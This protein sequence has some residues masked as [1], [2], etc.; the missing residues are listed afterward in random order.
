MARNFNTNQNR[1]LYVVKGY[2]TAEAFNA[3]DAELSEGDIA[4]NVA[5]KGNDKR[6]YLQYK[7]ADT[8]LRSPLID[9][10]SFDYGKA[11]K[12]ADL[13][14][15]FKSQIVTLDESVNGGA[16]VV[17]QDYILRINLRQWIGMSDE[18]MYF[19]DAVVHV[20]S[21]TSTAA[22]FYEAM[23]KQLNL[24]FAREIGATV[25]SNPYLK[26]EVVS[27]AT[28]AYDPETKETTSLTSGIKITE[29]AQPWTRGLEQQEH[30]LFDAMPTTIFSNGDDVI[31][32]KTYEATVKKANV[33]VGKTGYGNGHDIADL[34]YFCMGERGDQY[35]MVGWPNIVPTTY[36]VEPDKEY[37]VVELHYAFRDTGANSYRSDKDITLVST[38][39]SVLASVVEALNAATALGEGAVEGFASV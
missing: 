25:D 10:K 30:V 1:Q 36:M 23:V 21:A 22:K 20:T 35:R 3:K 14:T 19:K 29:K 7:G 28:D 32:G 26:F 39:Q 2:K 15:P 18:D 12:A 27:E 24:C 13:R 9:P 37:N 4:V 17:G 6:V 5:G 38:D 31:W 8:V 33:E 16:P 11:V 34:E